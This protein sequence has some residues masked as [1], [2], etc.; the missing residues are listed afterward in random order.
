MPVLLD[1]PLIWP[2]LFVWGAVS[3]GIYTMALIELGER[4]SDAMLVAGNAAFSLMWGVGGIA[5]SPAV[6]ASMDFL[7]APRP[8]GLAWPALSRFGDC[9]CAVRDSL[10]LEP[11]KLG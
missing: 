6:G 7:G 1:T 11:V 5:V 4:F 10:A 2:V 9:P 3:F 8:A